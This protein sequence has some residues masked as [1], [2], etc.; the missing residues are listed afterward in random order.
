VK[1][2]PRTTIKRKAL[3]PAFA[4]SQS[5]L[6]SVLGVNRQLIQ[7]HCKQP[8][9]PG[10][11]ANGKYPVQGWLEYLTIC[12][13]VPVCDD[14]GSRTKLK[15]RQIS[16]QNERLALELDI[17]RGRY[18]LAQDVERWGAELGAAVRKVATQLRKLAPA[19]AGLMVPEIES[20]L[21]DA[22]IEI[23]GQLHS[24]PDRGSKGPNERQGRRPSGGSE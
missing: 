1:S 16:L 22:E 7:W 9:N 23:L 21:R 5:E 12:G 4:G 10:R 3:T 6:A 19:L 18:V 14:A 13:R 17:R 11:R 24:L 2:E 20:R 15:A 8:G